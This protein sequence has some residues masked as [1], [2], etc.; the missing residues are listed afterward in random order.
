MR[1]GDYTWP[2]L[3]ATGDFFLKASD[4]RKTAIY[5]LPGNTHISLQFLLAGNDGET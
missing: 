5:S 3:T 4:A 1:C 2:M